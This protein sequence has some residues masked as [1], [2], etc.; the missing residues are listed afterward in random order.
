MANSRQQLDLDAIVQEVV[1]RLVER[2]PADSPGDCEAE[3][4]VA[5][6]VISLATL[7]NRL[8]GVQRV[9]IDAVAVVTP[10]ARD[11][12]AQR[13]IQLLRGGVVSADCRIFCDPQTSST[14]RRAL[15]NAEG[16]CVEL[17]LATAIRSLHDATADRRTRCIWLTS[18]PAA[19][20]CLMNRNPNLRAVAPA[21]VEQL[22]EAMSTFDANVC[23][24]DSRW[25]ADRLRRL[26]ERFRSAA[27]DCNDEFESLR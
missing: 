18:R 5:D 9:R 22:D 25:T 3:L 8:Q 24:L 16:A 26:V 19:S 2:S 10:A 27:G 11:E 1:R 23:V 20:A 13:K 21:A 12:L 4:L 6:R 14:S 17:D 7:E 15:S